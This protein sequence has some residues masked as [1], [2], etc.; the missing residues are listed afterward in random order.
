MNNF[1]AKPEHWK[2]QEEWVS[3]PMLGVDS[4][5]ILELRARVEALEAQAG[6]Y[7][8]I[9]DSSTLPPVAMNQELEQLFRD[10]PTLE[11]GLRAI[12]NLG[13]EHGQAG[14]REVAEPAPVAGGLVERVSDAITSETGSRWA[15]T[16]ARAAILE[17]ARWL[18][19][20]HGWE[21]GAQGLEREATQ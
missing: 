5:C 2:Y 7:P 15:T 12:Y 9:P 14:S 3:N 6:N 20:S 1:K 8:V 10:M 11:E 17:V 19:E 18:R 21:Q 4:S 13:I 16:E